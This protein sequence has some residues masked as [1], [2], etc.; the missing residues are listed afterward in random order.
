MDNKE[1]ELI[2]DIIDE[3]LGE[4][5]QHNDYRCQVAYDCPVCSYEIKGLD[6][7]DRK[8]NLEINYKSNVYK[9]WSCAETH[10]THGSLY[11]LIKKYGTPKQ[12]KKYQLLKPDIIEDYKQRPQKIIKLPKEFI[13]FNSVSQGLKLTH[14]YKQAYN[15]LKKRNISD[16][17]I[18]KFNIGFCYTGIYQNRIIIPSYDKDGSLNYF[19][20]RSYL[21]KTKFK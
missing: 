19:I 18:D 16:G 4:R 21:N 15:Y 14:Y 6:E 8:G 3:I 11:K 13:P 12:L 20:A 17:M 2:I 9:C 5:R 7:G 1:Y 10:D